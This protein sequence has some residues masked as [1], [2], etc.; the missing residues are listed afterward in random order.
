MSE[1]RSRTLLLGAAGLFLLGAVALLGSHRCSA[2]AARDNPRGRVPAR[3]PEAVG[4]A[5]TIECRVFEIPP[6]SAADPAVAMI[7]QS[8]EGAAPTSLD[9]AAAA[10][11]SASMDTLVAE[12]KATVLSTPRAKV[13]TSESAV[14][15]LASIPGPTG[16]ARFEL[17]V[18]YRPVAREDGTTDLA[19]I[20][21][22][23]RVDDGVEAVLD[24]LG[25]P[26]GDRASARG[27]AT[28]PERGA[29]VWTR[30]LG[31]S[32]IVVVAQPRAG[33]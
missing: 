28:V 12:G 3:S 5:V 22:A 25:L 29:A 4:A 23:K 10:A 18:E 7:V 9:A 21:T 27:S 1:T 16:G 31:D 19:A 33:G 15:S 14:L 11:L 20:F 6:A 2:D 8:L 30:R 13:R 26:A 24:E 32:T 17:N